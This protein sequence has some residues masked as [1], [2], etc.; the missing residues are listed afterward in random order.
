MSTSQNTITHPYIATKPSVLLDEILSVDFMQ[1]ILA[2]KN[3]CNRPV[4]KG[5]VN[6]YKESILNKEWDE[7]TGNS[8]RFDINGNLLDGQHRIS[9]FVEALTPMKTIVI[10]GIPP[11]SMKHIDENVPRNA[12]TRALLAQGIVPTKDSVKY[13]AA[14]MAIA[15]SWILTQHNLCPANSSTQS[16]KTSFDKIQ[17]LIAQKEQFINPALS[18]GENADVRRVGYR[19][20]VAQYF[21]K[22]AA[23]AEEFHKAV[24]GDGANLSSGSPILCLRNYLRKVKG[25]GSQII[26]QDYESTVSA[27]HKFHN[28]QT[29]NKISQKDTWDF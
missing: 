28:G 1:W 4:I 23:K 5:R 22:D 11:K 10:F 21:E 8:V 26:K 29:L 12:A 20:A 19:T 25:G 13:L 2:E 6:Q 15:K 24:S 3:P 14:K 27:I 17:E 7:E 16:K 9:A 18:I